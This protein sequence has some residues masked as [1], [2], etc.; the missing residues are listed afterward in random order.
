MSSFSLERSFKVAVANGQHLMIKTSF[1][2]TLFKDFNLV[3]LGY[4][5]AQCDVNSDLLNM[6]NM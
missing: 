3:Q 5:D 6:A 2:P 1:M 4:E